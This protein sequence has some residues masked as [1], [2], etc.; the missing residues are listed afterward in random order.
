M[1]TSRSG[2]AILA[3]R[4]DVLTE[5]PNCKAAIVRPRPHTHAYGEKL[6]FG[7]TE[8]RRP[9]P[10]ET[11]LDMPNGEDQ[12]NG[13]ASDCVSEPGM[14][15]EDLHGCCS[16]YLATKFPWATL[17][18]TIAYFFWKRSA[19]FLFCLLVQC[20]TGSRRRY[21]TSL[22]RT[23]WLQRHNAPTAQR[24]NGT[25]TSFLQLL[26]PRGSF[27]RIASSLSTLYQ[28]GTKRVASAG[29]CFFY[30]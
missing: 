22:P 10:K 21:P 18:V 24:S 4:H 5:L 15:P 17:Q 13:G 23:R 27:S 28:N 19:P 25:P 20:G 14:M 16:S 7:R 2:A 9:G 26:P 3:Q 12:L 8:D 29:A 1:Q 30:H 11:R 6:D